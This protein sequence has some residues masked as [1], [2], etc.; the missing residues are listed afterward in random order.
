MSTEDDN[1]KLV[2]AFCQSWNEP[3]KAATMLA[4]D[5]SVRMYLEKPAIIG[6]AAVAASMKQ[7]LAKIKVK[8]VIDK[9]FT[10]GPIVVTVRTDTIIFPDKE[11]VYKLV[12]IFRV[13][14]GKIQEWIDYNAA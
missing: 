9:T 5:A 1:V 7:Y 6:A 11:E 13:K 12:G 10:E 4:D 14:N 3:D 2:T 8:S